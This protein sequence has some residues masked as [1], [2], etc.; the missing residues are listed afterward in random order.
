MFGTASPVLPNAMTKEWTHHASTQSAWKGRAHATSLGG[1]HEKKKNYDHPS[2]KVTG[3]G[4][5]ACRNTQKPFIGKPR[6]CIHA[7]YIKGKIHVQTSKE[8]G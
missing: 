6:A 4:G 8:G 2:K 3:I 7:W 5:R 1:R